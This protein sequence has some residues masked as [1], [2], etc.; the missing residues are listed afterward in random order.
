[1]NKNL[2]E[3]NKDLINLVPILHLIIPVILGVLSGVICKK[4]NF[5]KTIQQLVTSVIVCIIY[6]TIITFYTSSQNETQ[7]LIILFIWN[8]ILIFISNKIS[9]Y[10]CNI[11]NKHS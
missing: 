5:T 9:L 1:M 7:L 8:S 4:I 3:I 10:F 2:I 11:K 6:L